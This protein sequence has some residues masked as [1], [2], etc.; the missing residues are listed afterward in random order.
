MKF[1]FVIDFMYLTAI[2]G[3]IVSL[4]IFIFSPKHSYNKRLLGTSLFA[5]SWLCLSAGVM[6]SQLILKLPHLFLTAAPLM[7]LVGPTSYLYVRATINGEHRPQKNDWVHFIPFMFLSLELLPFYLKNTAY[8]THIVTYYLAHR[9]DSSFLREGFLEEHFHFIFVVI[10]VLFYIY[11]QR[12]AIRGFSAVT[13]VKIKNQNEKL[14]NWLNLYTLLI[15]VTFIVILISFILR[16][17][18]KVFSI[19]PSIIM[20]INL[21]VISLILVARPRI[22]YGFDSVR[23]VIDKPA[24]KSK[25]EPEHKGELVERR[26]AIDDLLQ[27]QQKYLIKGYSLVDMA[28]ELNIPQ[29]LLSVIINQEYHI[30]FNNLINKYRIEYIINNIN[31]Q[32]IASYTFESIAEEA[33]FN[34]RVTF[35]RAFIKITGQ[36]PTAY[37]KKEL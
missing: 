15:S 13:T 16:L 19:V 36:T 34:S 32:K 22:L 8:K 24:D 30:S 27:K 6:Y 17:Y 1:D 12:N 33:G 20:S 2:Y 7:Y 35:Y 14:L 11:L 4:T 26:H 21:F 29:H 5:Y 23:E 18:I 25:T 28:N 9:E 3:L 10:L 37:F 31:Q